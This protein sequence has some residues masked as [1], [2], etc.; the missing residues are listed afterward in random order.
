MGG[1]IFVVD[2]HR[3]NIAKEPLSSAAPPAPSAP[4]LPALASA[5][6]VLLRRY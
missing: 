6:L 3:R 4:L 1:R 5:A 2:R